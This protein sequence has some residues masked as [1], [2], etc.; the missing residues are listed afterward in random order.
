MKSGRP[1]VLITAGN[2]RENIDSVR[3]WSNIFTGRTG[4]DI[5]YAMSSVADVCLLTSNLEHVQE[6][7]GGTKP[8]IE[9]YYFESHAHLM[10]LIPWRLSTRKYNAVFMTA[11]VS[12][13][14]PDGAYTVL[15]RKEATDRGQEVWVVEKVQQPKISSAHQ[16]LAILG[17]PT[18]KVIDQFRTVWKYHG[19]LFKFKLEVGLDEAELVAVAQASREHSQ[20]DVIVANTLEMVHSPEP[21]A[22]IIDQ[23]TTLKVPRRELAQALKDQ[24]LKRLSVPQKK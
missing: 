2:T 20:A 12:D 15:S 13:Y 18:A 1:Q 5:A 3:W 22:L 9:V 8:K 6:L 10:N 16:T 19:L 23:H 7:I 17:K 14:V 11:A 24:L 21:S 4:L